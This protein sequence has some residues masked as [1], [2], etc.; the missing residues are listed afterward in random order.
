MLEICYIVIYRNLLFSWDFYR[1]MK[2]PAN[3]SQ[4]DPWDRNFF[5]IFRPPNFW[6]PDLSPSNFNLSPVAFDRTSRRFD[7][8]FSSFFVFH[9][10]IFTSPLFWNFLS[11]FF[12]LYF[13]FFLIISWT[14]FI[15][16][17]FYVLFY[18]V[19][20]F[21]NHGTPFWL[22][23]TFLYFYDFC[24]CTF[25]F[26]IFSELSGVGWVYAFAHTVYQNLR[27]IDFEVSK[28]TPD[29]FLLSDSKN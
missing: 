1:K 5:V 7:R 26:V 23:F 17:L 20:K 15:F 16:L 3:L 22:I 21:Y 19:T 28:F 29:L 4:R 27:G 13:D 18:F 8:T 24:L 11:T 12:F 9:K 10:I 25:F 6:P 2:Q 14:F